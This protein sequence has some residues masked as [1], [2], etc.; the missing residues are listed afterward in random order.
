MVVMSMVATLAWAGAGC[1][2]TALRCGEVL[3]CGGDVVGSWT[4]VDLCYDNAA[5]T[6]EIAQ[7][8]PGATV[9]IQQAS[10]AGGMT[11]NSDLSYT[12]TAVITQKAMLS[13]PVG[14]PAFNTSSCAEF[15]ATLRADPNV[16]GGCAGSSTCN[17]SVEISAPFLGTAG[18]YQLVGTQLAANDVSGDSEASEYC[19]Q[20]GLIHFMSV[21]V[22]LNMPGVGPM[23]VTTDVVGR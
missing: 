23:K 1:G 15:D 13:V 5:L 8:C 16:V 17:C 10:V 11:F 20:D 9:N 12:S 19:V 22:T 14:C 18:S 6:A 21:A 3:P 4:M 7:V 2:G